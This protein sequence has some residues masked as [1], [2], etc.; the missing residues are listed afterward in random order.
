VWVEVDAGHGAEF[1]CDG[2]DEGEGEV[3]S[4]A[5]GDGEES[6]VED[7]FDG[8]GDSVVCG[9]EIAWDDID[10]ACVEDLWPGPIGGIGDGHG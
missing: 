6:E 5:D 2:S 1:V 4:A 7:C 8:L 3:V 9:V 10:I